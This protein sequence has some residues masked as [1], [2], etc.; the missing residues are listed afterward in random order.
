MIKSDLLSGDG[1]MIWRLVLLFL[2]YWVLAAHFLRYDGIF[3]TALV[4]LAPMVIL[5]KHR[6]SVYILQAGLIIAV[7][8]VWIPTTISIAQFRIAMGEPWLRMSC[9][10][11]G[12]IVFSLLSALLISSV[13]KKKKQIT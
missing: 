2:S 10:M 4:A 7:V 8:A 5:I 13:H 11:F 12:V 3:L 6:F 9:I 1:V